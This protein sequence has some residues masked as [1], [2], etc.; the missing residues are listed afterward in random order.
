MA[1]SVRTSIENAAKPQTVVEEW[2]GQ[3]AAYEREFKQ[4]QSR[5]DKI[6]KKYRGPTADGGNGK[7]KFNILWSNVQTLLPATFARIPKADVS[8]RFHD[9]DQVGR[10]SSLLLERS[11]EFEMEQ[12][13]DFAD[14]MKACVLDRFLGGRGTA[15]ARYEP[16]IRAAKQAA[17]VDGEQVTDKQ[18]EPQEELDY[19]CAP[20]DYVHWRDFGHTVARTWDE[21]TAVWRA[22]YMRRPA[23]VA[24]FGEELGNKIP[25][26]STPEDLK[27]GEMGGNGDNLSQA[28]VY[29]IWDK[30]TKR[31][32]W[33]SK[34]QP[35]PLDVK[36]DPLG[37]QDFF[38]CPKPLYATTTNES[39]IPV[40]DFALYQD[41]ARELDTLAE[42]IDGL[43]QMLQVKGVY[44][45]SIG[46]LAR[47]FT[48][49][50]NGT[51]IPVKNW[52]AFS[53]K[54][55]LAG[56][57]DLVELKPIYEALIAA[58]EAVQQ[59]LK[60]IYD[61][62]GLSDIV[63]G[64]SEASETATAQRIKGQ[65]ASLRL[66]SM[67]T[68]VARFASQL[69]QLKA[70]I[71]CGKFAPETILA[72]SAAK[73][74]SPVD[75]QAVIEA[76][77]LLIGPER[78]A[79]PEADPG[80]NPMRIFRIEVNADSM[81]QIDEQE[82]K[83]NRIE[84]IRSNG[85][86][87]E[88]ALPLAQAE[89]AISPLIA[90]L[91]KFGVQA[92]KVGKSI[93]G[94]FDSVIDKLTQMA[95]QPRPQKPDPEMAKVQAQQQADQARL[96][97][98]QQAKAAD[99][100]FEQQKIALESQAKE[101]EMQFQAQTEDQKRQ[102]EAAM[103]QAEAQQKAELDRY[104][105]DRDNETKIQVAEIAA[106]AT[107]DAGQIKAAQAAEEND[108]AELTDTGGA[109]A[110]A[111]GK[112]KKRASAIDRLGQMH[113]QNQGT[114]QKLMEKH[115]QTIQVVGDLAKAVTKPRMAIRG[116]DGK[117]AGLQ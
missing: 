85:E 50:T 70:Q 46:A 65:Y 14:T 3:I 25:L 108:T 66:K 34:A 96:Q 48:E 42:R 8:R 69:I 100:Q 4:W 5:V 109:A 107:I 31:A 103:R 92:F 37:L 1:E 30:V 53:E 61:L 111:T 80:P 43:I 83:E 114:M 29:E 87:M 89:P 35:E 19:E 73:Q 113:D 58:Y 2:T 116:P 72:E 7:S 18:D 33:I 22:V 84:F 24:R 95:A 56:A 51:L 28:K 106:Q 10:V 102:H 79:D 13:T 99:M 74:L 23:L 68:E 97:A 41:Q 54:N 88:K 110:K 91:W 9:P 55:G 20:V 104:K 112:T 32:I 26:D 94:E 115:D 40:P 62:T 81:V 76:M 44:D 59:V 36:D 12:Y 52:A 93:E 38:P 101:R 57:I 63:R 27:K 67:Q 16:H 6:L 45:D 64:Q 86:F 11:L 15:W 78:M 17:P 75:Q 98:D 71:I 77:A 105:I 90:T 47:I 82:E 49:G 117:I 60:Q 21:V 39:L